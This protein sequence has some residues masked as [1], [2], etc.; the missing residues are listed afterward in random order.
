V[1]QKL[2]S[3]FPISALDLP[4]MAYY[5]YAVAFLSSRSST[6]QSRD[7]METRQGTLTLPYLT[8]PYLTLPYLTASGVD[9][10]SIVK[11]GKRNV[12]NHVRF[13]M[14]KCVGVVMLS[15]FS[16]SCKQEVAPEV[17]IPTL[18]LTVDSVGQMNL[19]EEK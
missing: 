9:S 11:S 14:R 10:S 16:I 1:R 2:I 19:C 3:L 12:H 15:F 8:L 18:A 4:L 13:T 17:H 7:A 6:E 5:I